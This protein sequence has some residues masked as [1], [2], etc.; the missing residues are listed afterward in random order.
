MG[1]FH[2]SGQHTFQQ[3]ELQNE[4]LIFASNLTIKVQNE[5]HCEL[6]QKNIPIQNLSF[7]ANDMQTVSFMG[8]NKFFMTA[9]VHFNHSQYLVLFLVFMRSDL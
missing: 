4:M 2:F 3:F 5:T 8:A 6:Y 1:H 7:N 9:I